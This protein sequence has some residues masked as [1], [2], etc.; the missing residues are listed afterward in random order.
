M[1]YPKLDWDKENKNTV[2]NKVYNL[3]LII[4]Y[5]RKSSRPDSY[6]DSIQFVF[7]KLGV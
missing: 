4:A 7:A 2:A 6:W 5:L 3:L 1:F